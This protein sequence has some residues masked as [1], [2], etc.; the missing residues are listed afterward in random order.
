MGGKSLRMFGARQGGDG[1]ARGEITTK[2]WKNDRMGGKRGR[3]Q[4]PGKKEQR[5]REAKLPPKSGRMTE[6]AVKMGASW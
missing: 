3:K 5:W 4:V 1:V 2:K 6:R